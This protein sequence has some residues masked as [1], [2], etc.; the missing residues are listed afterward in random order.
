M[1][2]QMSLPDDKIHHKEQ[3]LLQL[4]DILQEVPSEQIPEVLSLLPGSN[5]SEL[6]RQL[7]LLRTHMVSPDLRMAQNAS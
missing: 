5:S 7:L 3:P 1:P 2:S 6:L 4:P